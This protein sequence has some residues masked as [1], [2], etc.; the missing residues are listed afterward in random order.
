MFPDFLFFF[1]GLHF[2]FNVCVFGAS[3]L[4]F[5]TVPFLVDSF[6]FGFTLWSW[7][8]GLD[9]VAVCPRHTV[10]NNFISSVV[11]CL[12]LCLGGNAKCAVP[13][14]ES[15]LVGM[16]TSNLEELCELTV[17]H[18]IWKGCRRFKVWI[19]ER[20]SWRRL[21]VVSVREVDRYVKCERNREMWL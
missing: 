7:V 6:C 14:R 1:R 15:V 5:N 11:T 13:G 20:L 12:D 18:F 10:A 21:D 4:G 9:F 16:S 2:S 19:R 8:G 3:S 17:A